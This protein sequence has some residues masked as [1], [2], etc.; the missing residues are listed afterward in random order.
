M[1]QSKV[2][3]QERGSEMGMLSGTNGL[4]KGMA[5]EANL[6]EIILEQAARPKINYDK[7]KVI[8]TIGGP[9]TETVDQLA[10]MLE[11]GMT[12]ARFDFTSGS[13]TLEQH[14]QTLENPQGGPEADQVPVRNLLRLGREH[15][16]GIQ[17]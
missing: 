6:A 10:E 17:E 3:L 2:K 13:R 15:L 4:R 1:T 12:V 16:R 7:C 14:L 11:A 9:L 5:K 8:V